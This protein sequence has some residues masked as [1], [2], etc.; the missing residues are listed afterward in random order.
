MSH[1]A[2]LSVPLDHCADGVIR[3]AGTRVT[4]DT[5]VAAYDEGCSAELIVN[6]YPSLKLAEVYSIISYLLQHRQEIDRYLLQREN[7]RQQVQSENEKRFP[8]EGF[9]DRLLA[10]RQVHF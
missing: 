6:Q 10:R 5:L 1:P 3:I 2:T 7:I 4:L 9:R 8:P